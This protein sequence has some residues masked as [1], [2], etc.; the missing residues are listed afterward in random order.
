MY[1]QFNLMIVMLI[2][3][4]GVVKNVNLFNSAW[5]EKLRTYE[6]VLKSQDMVR[7]I[8]FFTNF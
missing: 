6:S 5:Y 1:E 3:C 2:L 8:V 7:V 4:C